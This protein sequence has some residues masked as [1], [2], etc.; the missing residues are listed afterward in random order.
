MSIWNVVFF[1]SFS[2]VKDKTLS[3]PTRA[4][5]KNLKQNK[6]PLLSFNFTSFTLT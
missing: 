1:C 5:G 6:T 4:F 3:K 2:F